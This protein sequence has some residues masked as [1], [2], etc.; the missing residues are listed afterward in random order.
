MVYA[1]SWLS[2]H[3]SVLDIL[4][5]HLSLYYWHLWKS[6]ILG[7]CEVELYSYIVLRVTGH[8]FELLHDLLTFCCNLLNLWFVL[9]R[10][11][12]V[13]QCIYSLWFVLNRHILVYQCI[14]SWRHANVIACTWLDI[15]FKNH[16]MV[17]ERH[18]W[19][20]LYMIVTIMVLL[21]KTQ[22]KLNFYIL[23]FIT[24]FR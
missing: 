1:L 10:L 14:Y 6:W 11:M 16:E 22:T 7:S 9:D 17:F 13:Y 12:L 3:H 2:L 18:H 23:M 20:D 5:L 19:H 15:A 24:W 4:C 8:K 21:F